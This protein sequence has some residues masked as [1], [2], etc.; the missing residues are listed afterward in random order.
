MLSIAHDVWFVITNLPA[1]LLYAL[2]EFVNAIV[3]GL[4]AFVQAVLDGIPIGMPA[5]PDLPPTFTDILGWIAWFFPVSTLADILVFYAAAWT[6]WFILSIAL[7]WVKA[8]D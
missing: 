7:R 4:A 6:M 2:T 8:M 1:F 3:A 5:P